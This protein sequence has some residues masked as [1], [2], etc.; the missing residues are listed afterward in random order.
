MPAKHEIALLDVR[1]E[2]EFSKA[3][4]LFAA[5]L[6]LEHIERVARRR[7]A[8]DNTFIVVYDK[9]EGL[10]QRAG[11]P[12]GEHGLHGCIA[13]G[14]GLDSW[15]STGGE[16][17][18]DDSVPSKAFGELPKYLTVNALIG[19]VVAATE[20]RVSCL[21]ISRLACPEA[22]IHDRRVTADLALK[23]T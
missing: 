17:P 3:H 8:R 14:R 12:I 1:S 4:S 6:A 7:I 16:I 5:N 15:R 19:L 22:G 20:Q 13:T 9:G 18:I 11:Q 2:A 21:L 23:H 10:A